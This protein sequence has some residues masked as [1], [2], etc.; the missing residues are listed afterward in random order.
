MRAFVITGPGQA[1]VQDVPEPSAGPGQVV[2]QVER[3]GVCGTDLEIYSGHMSYLETGEASYP[4]RIGHEWCGVV[5]SAGEG[6]DQSWIGRWV[7][8]DT[9]LGCGHCDRCQRG[10]HYLCADR[11]EIGI[12]NGWPGALAEYLLVPARALIALPDGIDPMNGAMVEPGGNALRAIDGANLTPGDRL[13]IIG[14]GTIGLLAA[15]FARAQGN[16]VHL[17]G[18]EPRTLDFARTLGFEHCWAATDLPELPF[19]AVIDAS[20]S[21]DV[22]A[23]AVRL[24]EPGGRLVLIGLSTVPSLVDTRVLALKD[25]TAAGVLGGS[26]GL[27]RA[28]RL[29]ATGAVDPRPLVA[30]TLPLDQAS[31]AL[32]GTRPA[33]WPPAPKIHINPHQ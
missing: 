20:N 25:V 30:A 28:A 10:R 33:A 7:A 2:V 21:A 3:A 18:A 9:M 14:P 22:P 4:I 8:G 13:L 27:T 24:V 11:Y 23:Q 19:D 12:R 29:Y 6:V 32:S 5:T 15:L 26:N 31:T 17:V 1:E 16:E